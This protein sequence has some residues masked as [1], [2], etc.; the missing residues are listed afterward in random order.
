MN[1]T[2]N[3]P[4]KKVNPA[5]FSSGYSLRNVPA[6]LITIAVEHAKRAYPLFIGYEPGEPFTPEQFEFVHDYWQRILVEPSL[7][8]L[9]ERRSA[10]RRCASK[11][12]LEDIDTRIFVIEFPKKGSGQWCSYRD[13]KPSVRLGI[14][15][16]SGVT[17]GWKYDD[18]HRSQLAKISTRSLERLLMEIMRIERC[19]LGG[20]KKI[21]NSGRQPNR[22]FKGHGKGLWSGSDPSVC[23]PSPDELEQA[24]AEL[25]REKAERKPKTETQV[26]LW[27]LLD[28][29]PT[30]F[31]DH[32]AAASNPKRDPVIRW[33]LNDPHRVSLLKWF[34]A[35]AKSPK[36]RAYSLPKYAHYLW[37]SHRNF[38]RD[39]NMV[40]TVELPN[41]KV[42]GKNYVEPEPDTAAQITA[43]TADD[44]VGLSEVVAGALP[45]PKE[46]PPAI[47]ADS[48]N[49]TSRPRCKVLPDG[50]DCE[51]LP[52]S[53][54]SEI[55]T[56]VPD[57]FPVDHS[58]KLH[59][60]PS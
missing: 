13:E 56:D 45:V 59:A 52:S 55:E 41:G 5:T 16:S 39:K 4:A 51:P 7:M 34:Q 27:D 6:W 29:L 58:Q 12:E 60:L 23:D 42:M 26:K 25:R 37:D 2:V 48:S 18:T 15:P 57:W 35:N 28:C 36:V 47:L 17:G 24:R 54:P 8:H 40:P 46:S 11:A 38:V 3:D 10:K 1:V 9:A 53:S 19:D 50:M 43:D 30:N 14:P 32:K 20:A 49:V 22:F 31:H 21:F 33:I 44:N